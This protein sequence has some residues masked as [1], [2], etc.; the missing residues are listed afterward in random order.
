VDADFYRFFETTLSWQRRSNPRDFLEPETDEKNYKNYPD[1]RWNEYLSAYYS[2]IQED[3]GSR[4]CHDCGETKKAK[5]FYAHNSVCRS[6]LVK[7]YKKTRDV[8]SVVNTEKKEKPKP[9]KSFISPEK[10]REWLLVSSLRKAIS[11]NTPIREVKE[12]FAAQYPEIAKLIRKY[13]LV[14]EN[15]RIIFEGVEYEATDE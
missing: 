12:N 11:D 5:Y 7:E 2:D 14:G 10:N 9:K 13:S 6:C 8:Y 4:I 15:Y 1:E 3:M